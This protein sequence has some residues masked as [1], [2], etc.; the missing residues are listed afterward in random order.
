LTE[1]DS[2]SIFDSGSV[3]KSDS[4]SAAEPVFVADSDSDFKTYAES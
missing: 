4:K 1:S 2:D 3:A